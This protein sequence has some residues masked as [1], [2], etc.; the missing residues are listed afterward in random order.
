MIRSNLSFRKVCINGG[1][2]VTRLMRPENHSRTSGRTYRCRRHKSCYQTQDQNPIRQDFRIQG[3]VMVFYLGVFGPAVRQY[4]PPVHEARHVFSSRRRLASAERH[5]GLSVPE[6][7]GKCGVA[8]YS[9]GSS[10][11]SAGKNATTVFCFDD[12]TSHGF[13]H[14]HCGTR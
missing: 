7:V 10:A 9:Y 5:S 13:T 8:G 6:S 14:T 1:V 4:G 12:T 3:K 11:R 2:S